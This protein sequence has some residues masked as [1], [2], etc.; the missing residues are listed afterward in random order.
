M[1]QP[2]IDDETAAT[3]GPYRVEAID[4]ATCESVAV[5]GEFATLSLARAFIV[6]DPLGLDGAG[7]SGRFYRAIPMEGVPSPTDRRGVAITVGATVRCYDSLYTVASFMEKYNERWSMDRRRGG[8]V[9]TGG[10]T[11]VAVCRSQRYGGLI[12]LLPHRLTVQ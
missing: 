1:P 4:A 7:P 5:L 9:R 8:L 3:L 6:T 10:M 12:C 2:I 11:T